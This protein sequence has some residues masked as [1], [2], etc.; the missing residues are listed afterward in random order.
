MS[1]VRL[2]LTTMTT[3]C[4]LERQK[5]ELLTELGSWTPSR[6]A[7]QPAAEEWS[8]LQMLD[9]ILRTER[10]ILLVVYRNERQPH[11]VGITDRIRTRFLQGVFRSDRKVRVPSSAKIVLPGKAPEL[12]LLRSDWDE[13]RATLAQNIER[14]TVRSSGKGLFKHPVGGWMDVQSVLEFLSVHLLHHGF[15]LARLRVASEHLQSELTITPAR[16][17]AL[18]AKVTS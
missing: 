7:F 16:D 15:Q 1:W 14:L 2:I 18:P 4:R 10:E 6:L 11:R 13:V 17:D 3:F 5:H 9:H 12:A 8:A